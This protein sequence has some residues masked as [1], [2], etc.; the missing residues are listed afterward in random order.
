[1]NEGNRNAP[2]LNRITAMG[3]GGAFLVALLMAVSPAAAGVSAA[4]TLHKPFKTLPESASVSV[5]VSGCAKAKTTSNPVWH[6]RTG[7]FTTAGQSNAPACKIHVGQTSLSQWDGSWNTQGQFYW[8]TVG[9]HYVSTAFKEAVTTSNAISSFGC[10]LNFHAAY[11]ECFAWSYTYVEAGL[12]VYNSNFST[13][14]STYA[15][16]ATNSS[17]QDNYSQRT[18]NPTC[19]LSGGNFSF[20]TNGVS[21]T[22]ASMTM[23]QNLTGAYSVTNKSQY[24]E[25]YF[26]I[27][28]FTITE[29]Y[30]IDATATS[31]V[32]STAQINMATAGN[33]FILGSL[34]FT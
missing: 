26:V 33:G 23:T 29:A 32:T 31:P 25:Y 24:Y 8:S 27:L 16:I 9:S 17:E 28:A 6:W 20:G 14:L 22:I 19:T 5:G 34:G 12:T 21:S 7:I 10:K 30:T 18:C 15:T 1:M 13:F 11:S 4:A 3:V 2:R